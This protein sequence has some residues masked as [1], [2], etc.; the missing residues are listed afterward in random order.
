VDALVRGQRVC[1]VSRRRLCFRRV[2]SIFSKLGAADAPRL[3]LHHRHRRSHLL[4]EDRR[5]RCPPRA[6]ARPRGS[7]VPPPLRH[8]RAL[9][10]SGLLCNGL[11][12]SHGGGRLLGAARHIGSTH[13]PP[14]PRLARRGDTYYFFFSEHDSA[15]C[16]LVATHTI[17]DAGQQPVKI[18][19]RVLARRSATATLTWKQLR[20]SAE[21]IVQSRISITDRPVTMEEWKIIAAAA[22][23]QELRLDGSD[24]SD[25]DLTQLADHQ[26]LRKL[27]LMN[28]GVTPKGLAAIKG[29]KDL[30]NLYLTGSGIDDSAAGILTGFA[31]MEVL[32]LSYTRVTD[33]TVVALADLKNL[34][35]LGIR[36]RDITDLSVPYFQKMTS[37][38]R[39]D[40]R[41]SRVSVEGVEKIRQALP[42]CNVQI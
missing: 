28:T 12:R 40:L 29:L 30:R 13:R 22:E 18:E 7:P 39:L 20:L 14:Q 33:N 15:V 6:A 9:P 3:R 23:L 26:Q 10:R 31:E 41:G 5:L 37:L 36:T 42:A 25:A 38:E 19:L 35:V 11:S 17:R 21:K 2:T 32:G 34:K 1:I 8:G 16:R 27:Y 4:V 24:V